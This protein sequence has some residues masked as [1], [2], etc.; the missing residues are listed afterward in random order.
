MQ[1][2]SF[3]EWLKAGRRPLLDFLRN[4]TSQTLFAGLAEFVIYRLGTVEGLAWNPTLML[5]FVIFGGTFLLAFASSASLFYEELFKEYIAWR[6]RSRRHLQQAFSTEAERVS[7]A[8]KLHWRVR[9][10]E[11]LLVAVWLA[12]L[13]FIFSAVL[14]AAV[15]MT[16][17]YVRQ[18]SKVT[19]G[20]SVEQSDT[21]RRT[22]G[23]G[24]P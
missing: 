16:K 22:P 2:P 6:V 8:I 7:V 17:G 23:A 24:T 12:S 1:R 5:S 18:S 4:L 11:P 13:L 9:R 20:P 19:A 21:T 14:I 15:F 10:R 3:S